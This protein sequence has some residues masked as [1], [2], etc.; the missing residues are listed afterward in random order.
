MNKLLNDWVIVK[1]TGEWVKKT[2]Q[3]IT[4]WLSIW[5]NE[6]INMSGFHSEYLL[7]EL[8]PFWEAANCA[9]TQELPS[10]LWNPKVHYRVH[11][12]PPLVPILSQIDSVYTIPFYLRSILI[13]STHLRLPLPSGLFPSGFP[14]KYF[15]ILVLNFSAKFAY[16]RVKRLLKYL[17]QSGQAVAQ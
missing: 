15:I 16:K 4:E 2:G 7:T 8:N 14:T 10:I 3:W 6:K 11:K 5:V 9:A 13:L 1:K 17:I 12:S